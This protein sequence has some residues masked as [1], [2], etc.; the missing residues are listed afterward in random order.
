ME[1][2]NEGKMLITFILASPLF[3]HFYIACFALL[4]ISHISYY[5]MF[6]FTTLMLTSYFSHKF[7]MIYS[8]WKEVFMWIYE[9]Y[10]LEDGY[11]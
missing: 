5:F 3:A 7:Y 1:I 4:G 8:L 2:Q 11:A 10:F 9:N 6:T